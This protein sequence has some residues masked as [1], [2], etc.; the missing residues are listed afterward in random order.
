MW[1]WIFLTYLGGVLGSR[2]DLELHPVP[3]FKFN[4][5]P[6]VLRQLSPYLSINQPINQSVY[7]WNWYQSVS[8]LDNL[9]MSVLRC[10]MW[11]TGLYYGLDIERF[12]HKTHMAV[13][14]LN[15][16]PC[17]NSFTFV[18]WWMLIHERYRGAG[19]HYLL[20]RCEQ[21][22]FMKLHVTVKAEIKKTK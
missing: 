21:V 16:L 13:V 7:L 17:G 6:L 2:N 22:R 14:I 9:T 12:L 1:V 8:K 19:R 4:L 18:S 5:F 20:P 10:H 15:V 3:H 11:V